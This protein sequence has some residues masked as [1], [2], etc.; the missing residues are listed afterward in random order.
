MRLSGW[1]KRAPAIESMS[2]EVVAALPP[3][4]ADLGAEADPE[5][6]IAWGDDPHLRYSVLVPTLAG[7][8]I[9]AVRPAGPQGGPGISA[10][11]IR[12]SKLTISELGID[13][14]G[15]HRIVAVQVET[16]VLKGVDDEADR[17]CEFVRGLISEVDDRHHAPIPIA[18]MQAIPVRAAAV[19]ASAQPAV[20]TAAPIAVVSVAVAA[21]PKPEPEPAPK[22]AVQSKPP[23][24]A[25][26]APPAPA[27][28]PPPAPAPTPRP[29]AAA[30]RKPTARQA[31]EAA[32]LPPAASRAAP[33]IEV[34][35][36]Q[37]I[38]PHPIEAAAPRK[39]GRP[40]SWR[41]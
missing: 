24:A 36:S 21:A 28:T 4:L 5:C 11:L 8:I 14:A 29:A 20:E 1:R 3:V 26:P 34:D 25:K 37:W 19:A 30:I 32:P 35:R 41:P 15:G 33:E 39:P 6:W 22:P 38:P 13:S 40:R 10:K 12:W 31:G 27:Q 18:V 7:L 2:G 17:I 16:I 23:P 9:A